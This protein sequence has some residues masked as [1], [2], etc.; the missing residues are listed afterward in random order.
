[1]IYWKD[2]IFIKVFE[3]SGSFWHVWKVSLLWGNWRKDS[4][5]RWHG[6]ATPFE[7]DSAGL[8][9]AIIDIDTII[10]ID[11]LT[12]VINSSLRNVC[13][14]DDVKT[15]EVSPI[16]VPNDNLHKDLWQGQNDNLHKDNCKSVIVWS[17]ISVVFERIITSKLKA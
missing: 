7:N 15:A 12:K 9:D 11:V 17:H 1:M 4:L 3:N 8:F 2:F 14:P 13:F 5:I 16:F 6:K 10:D